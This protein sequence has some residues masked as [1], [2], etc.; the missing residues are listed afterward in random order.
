LNLQQIKPVI[1]HWTKEHAS[2]IVVESSSSFLPD[3][4]KGCGVWVLLVKPAGNGGFQDIRIIST[5]AISTF[6]QLNVD[7]SRNQRYMKDLHLDRLQPSR[8]LVWR[9][10]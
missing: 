3:D 5:G 9:M 7:E 2:D 1:V 10:S 4:E 8:F 6:L